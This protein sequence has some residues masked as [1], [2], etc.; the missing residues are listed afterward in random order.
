MPAKKNDPT[1]KT[2]ARTKAAAKTPKTAPAKSP[3]KPAAAPVAPKPAKAAEKPTAAKQAPETV[4][5]V[6]PTRTRPY[7]AG[8]IVAKHGLAAGIT[9]AMVA[10]LDKAYGKPNPRES[11][12]CLK[13]AHH[14]AR[15]FIGLDENAIE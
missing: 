15:G 9:D 8:V 4:P 14:A 12:F 2:A 11:A 5:G 1:P 10:E 3:D 7:L 6:R 13:N